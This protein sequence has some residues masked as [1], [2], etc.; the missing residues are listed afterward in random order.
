MR[1]RLLIRNASLVALLLL[2]VALAIGSLL[3]GLMSSGFDN[4]GT[5]SYTVLGLAGAI[6]ALNLHLAFTRPWLYSLRTRGSME[7]YR[8]ASGVP[9][10]GTALV[11]AAIMMAFGDWSFA[12]GGLL[13]LALDVGG[14]PWF[15]AAISRDSSFWK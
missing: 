4:G 14:T 3:S 9:L 7:G 10:V 2:P 6:A 1:F 15:L 12:A 5:W 11:V 13:V 8:R